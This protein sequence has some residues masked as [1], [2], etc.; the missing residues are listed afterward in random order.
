MPKLT[1]R[2]NQ[3]NNSLGVTL[4]LTSLPSYDRSDYE[5]FGC[6]K[7]NDDDLIRKSSESGGESMVTTNKIVQN[8]QSN[9]ECATRQIIKPFSLPLEKLSATVQKIASLCSLISSK[10]STSSDQ[11]CEPVDTKV[12]QN[13]ETVS[14]HHISKPALPVEKPSTEKPKISNSS[15]SKPPIIKSEQSNKKPRQRKVIKPTLLAALTHKLYTESQKI[16]SSCSLAPNRVSGPSSSVL[17]SKS[18][19]P[20]LPKT[21]LMTPSQRPVPDRIA[22]EEPTQQPRADYIVRT[23]PVHFVGGNRVSDSE[24]HL[25][26]LANQRRR[27]SLEACKIF[28]EQNTAVIFGISLAILVICCFYHPL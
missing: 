23:M 10:A 1:L 28:V 12:D 26:F 15:L 4:G 27:S 19:V 14:D 20:A 8:H 25:F 3:L 7:T 9:H 21:N 6:E 24:D 11:N 13:C 5:F 17:N 18:S 22:F 16:S 2:R